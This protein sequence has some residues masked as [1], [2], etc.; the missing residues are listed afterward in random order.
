MKISTRQIVVAGVMSAIAI[1][2]GAT[3]LGFIPFI[4]GVAITIMHVPVIIGAVLE[5]PWVGAVVGLLF[6][7]LSMIWAYVAPTGG[8]DVYFQHPLVAVL[9]RVLIGPFAYLVYRLVRG[10]KKGPAIAALVVILVLAQAGLAVAYAT[11]ALDLLESMGLLQSSAGVR[12]LVL[13]AVLVLDLLSLAGFYLVLRL[14]G[15]IAAVGA[16]AVAGTLTNTVLVLGMIGLLGW[17]GWVKPPLPA[18]LLLGIGL[19]NGIPEI[20]AAVVLTVAVVAA[21]KQ[22]E[23]GRQG[24][25]IFREEAGR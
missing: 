1:L 23:V 6:G 8:G 5:G 20:I 18:S 14:R 10:E 4:L 11:P 13:V 2:L 3:R 17:L 24:A 25:R 19:A 16:A 7:V 22:I 21:W 9:P 12:T 15:E